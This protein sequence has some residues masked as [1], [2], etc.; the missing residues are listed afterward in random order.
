MNRE[1]NKHSPRVDEEMKEESRSFT[2]GAPVES[3][4]Q[5]SREKEG[6]SDD[7][8]S[9]DAVITTGDGDTPPRALSHEEL[10]LRQDLARFLDGSIFP[11]GRIEIMANAAEHHAPPEILDRFKRLPDRSFEGFPEVWAA[12]GGRVEGDRKH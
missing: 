12:L 1:S 8:P 5:E 9:P 10:E 11:A 7:Q 6:G 4:A 2:Q 3:R